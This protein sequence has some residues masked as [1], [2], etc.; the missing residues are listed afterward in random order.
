MKALPKQQ[1]LLDGISKAWPSIHLSS[2][3]PGLEKPATRFASR[4]PHSSSKD[5]F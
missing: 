2:L 4:P 5:F 1:S 3:K